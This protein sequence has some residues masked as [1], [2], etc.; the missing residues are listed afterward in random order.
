MKVYP[1]R[2]QINNV[3]YLSLYDKDNNLII[4]SEGTAYSQDCIF[5]I[6]EGLEFVSYEDTEIMITFG[7]IMKK[8][9]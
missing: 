8:F 4:R 9:Y 7:S 2:E 1:K 5:L 3:W 6:W